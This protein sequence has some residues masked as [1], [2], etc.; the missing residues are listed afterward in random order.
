[1]V[2]RPHILY[3]GFLRQIDRLG[4]GIVRVLLEGGLHPHMLLR[5][6]LQGGYE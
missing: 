5:R 1:M 4:D 2:D 3:R 6:D